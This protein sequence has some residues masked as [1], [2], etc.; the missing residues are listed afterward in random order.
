MWSN[1]TDEI[2]SFP[3]YLSLKVGAVCFFL[4]ILVSVPLA[5]Y[6]RGR[7]NL[8]RRGLAFLVTVPLVFP[9]VA[10]GFI[11]LMLFGR[12]G[13]FGALLEAAFGIR[14]VFSQGAVI[15]AA[16]L[17]GLPLLVRPLEAGLRRTEIKKLEKASRTLGCG[18][19]RTFIFVSLPQVFPT[20]ASGLLLALARAWGEVGITLMIG[21]NIIGHSNTLSLEIYNSV[22]YGQF[23]RA[24]ALCFIL[25]A[26]GL[27]FYLIL[28]KVTPPE[29]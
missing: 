5:W 8:V 1:L 19:F 2:F 6:L 27:I 15:F 25:G 11:I 10:L 3:A 22:S 18:P 17:A 16:F 26:A 14:V 29:S 13:V 28:E 20:L 9:P 21:G 12:Q 7:K 24:M 4:H 23:D